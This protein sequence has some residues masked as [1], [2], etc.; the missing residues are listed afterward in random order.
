MALDIEKLRL[1]LTEVANS[2]PPEGN[3]PGTVE[4]HQHIADAATGKALWGF[5]EWLDAASPRQTVGTRLQQ[6][7][8]MLKDAGIERPG[9]EA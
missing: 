2:T 3:E 1:T 5:V 9:G 6:L 7:K 8:A 4:M